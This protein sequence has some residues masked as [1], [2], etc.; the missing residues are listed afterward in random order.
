[1]ESTTGAGKRK[2]CGDGDGWSAAVS[3]GQVWDGFHQVSVK[4]EVAFMSS[5][6]AS[7][8]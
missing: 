7:L 1:M 8:C 5:G 4:W 2:V 6:M 3:I